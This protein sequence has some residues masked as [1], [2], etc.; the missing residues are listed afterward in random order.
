MLVEAVKR[1]RVALDSLKGNADAGPEEVV[2][3]VRELEEALCDVLCGDARQPGAEWLSQ[4]LEML[5]LQVD[6]T[7]TVGPQLKKRR[8]I[9]TSHRKRT[10]NS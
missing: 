1:L 4:R 8:V 10:R 9:P 2:E 6:T 7:A 5:M 3:I